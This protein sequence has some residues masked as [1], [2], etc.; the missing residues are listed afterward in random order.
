MWYKGTPPPN[1][2]ATRLCATTRPS[3]EAPSPARRRRTV[4]PISA[5]AIS[6][7]AAALRRDGER[8]PELEREL[9]LEQELELEHELGQE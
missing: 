5:W 2:V 6:N 1:G 7:T 4:T 3:S 8:E 9:E